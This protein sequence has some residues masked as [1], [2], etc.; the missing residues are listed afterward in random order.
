MHGTH[1]LLTSHETILVHQHPG[2]TF[3]QQL[4][5]PT[6][7]SHLYSLYQLSLTDTLSHM[8]NRLHIV[9]NLSQD[10]HTSHSRLLLVPLA[11]D[12]HF[13]PHLNLVHKIR[14]IKETNG[15]H[16]LTLLDFKAQTI[17]FKSIILHIG[18]RHHCSRNNSLLAIHQF[19]NRFTLK[20]LISERKIKQEVPNRVQI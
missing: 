17:T 1:S 9:L 11:K 10:F 4:N 14:L 2:E 8:V 18:R 7:E 3:L 16:S 13:C 5:S 19:K 12:S 20:I 6:F 15:N